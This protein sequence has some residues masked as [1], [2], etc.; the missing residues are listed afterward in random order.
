MFGPEVRGENL[1][2]ASKRAE[3][4]LAMVGLSDADL[5]RK[6][7]TPAG[8]AITSWKWLRAMAE[9]EAHHRGQIYLMLGMLDV[10]TPPLDGLTAEEVRARSV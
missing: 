7:Q 8:V 2:V 6:I 10:P 1:A 9:H 4:L 3:D 5:Q